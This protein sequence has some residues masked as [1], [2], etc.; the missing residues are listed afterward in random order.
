MANYI[1]DYIINNNIKYYLDD[2]ENNNHSLVWFATEGVNNIN[3]LQQQ[4]L[5]NKFR[6]H[7]KH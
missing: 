4:Y 3:D 6:T 2:V 7:F 5:I 1:L